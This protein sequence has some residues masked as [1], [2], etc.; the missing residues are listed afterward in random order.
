M[1][2]LFLVL[3]FSLFFAN[4]AAETMDFDIPQAEFTEKNGFVVPEISGYDLDGTGEEVMLPF[5]KMVFSSEV[6]KV[7]ILKQHKVTLKAPLKKGGPLYRLSDMQKVRT[8]TPEKRPL[9]SLSKFAFDRKPT[10]KRERKIY[11]FDFYPLIPSGEKEVVKIDKIRVTTKEKALF[12]MSNTQSGNSLLIL[13]TEYFMSKSTEIENYIAA[14]KESG[15]SVSVATEKDYEGGELKG[16]ERAEKIREY[17]KK[18]Y[19]N[20]DYLL[21]IAGTKLGGNEVPMIMTRPC[22][23]DNPKADDVPTDI[24]YAE[25]TEDM[26]GNKNGIYGEYEDSIEYNF[27][28]VVGRIPIYEEN[29]KDADKILARTTEFIKNGFTKSAYY[30][31][32]LFPTTI[33]YY[34]NQDN[35]PS[36]PK[37]DGAYVAE[38]LMKESIRDPFV[39]KTLVEKDGLDPSEFIDEEA[40]TYDSMLSNWNDG[41]GVIFWM[42]HG[43]TDIAART[44]W[45]NDNNGNGIPDKSQYEF[46][47]PIFV[48]NDLV[49][50]VQTVTPF[51]FQGSCL[52]GSIQAPGSL[53]YETLK[54]TAVGVVAASQDS[55]GWI[56]SDY[57]L[58]SQDMFAY[59]AVFTDAL[60]NNRIPSEALLEAKEKWSNRGTHL[61][62]KLITNYIGDPS[63]KLNIQTC[64]EDSD[65]DDTIFC[66][67]SEICV[68]GFCERAETPAPCT[69]NENMC[70]TISCDEAA[71]SCKTEPVPDGLSCGTPENPCAE[72]RECR[73]G[74]CTDIGLKDCS[75]LDSE[76]SSGTCNPENGKCIITAVNEGKS[77][78][79][80]K[81]C[82][83]NEV[84]T[85]GFCEGEAP[86]M[87]KASECNKTECSESAGFFEVADPAQNWNECTTS[88]GR[89]GYCDYGTCTPKKEQAEEEQEKKSSSSSGCLPSIF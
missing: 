69:E 70:E 5:K 71:K 45:E 87:P 82:V 64:S 75:H 60:A 67:G 31:K 81:I 1:K 36:I 38:Y 12:P 30:R 54:N 53:A 15:F 47:S 34:A 48:D 7:E 37:M 83:K 16:F 18:V 77:C 57:N 10:F 65:C 23:T 63:L 33:P 68:E 80:G 20:Y 40:I 58:S 27:E 78:S 17:L 3:V 46:Y 6:V 9:P 21:I 88:D 52:N 19:K 66:N 89:T 22:V 61:T 41:Y 42:A 62:N 79:T 86:D 28:L 56:A 72:T 73:S 59:G 26:D 51:V 76:C 35:D 4:A 32:I 25:L 13:T 24:F 55:Y 11:S 14:K 49:S 74:Q 84:C 50:K 2:R 29:V 85:Q 43:N 44:I 8:A 39:S